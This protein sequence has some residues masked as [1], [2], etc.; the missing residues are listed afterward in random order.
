MEALIA[1]PSMGR[2]GTI[3]KG[4]MRNIP[5]EFHPN[6]KFFVPPDE[7]AKYKRAM[8]NC[9][10]EKVEVI[11]CRAE[12]IAATRSYIGGYAAVHGHTKFMMLD[13]DLNQFSVR[14]S[15]VDTK[16]RKAMKT[17]L[18]EMFETVEQYL[19]WYMHLS[20]STRFHN[21]QFVGER[22]IVVENFRMLRFL[23][24]RTDIFNTCQ[25]GRVAIAEDFDVTLQLLTR[26]YKNAVLHQWTH[27]QS[28]T[29][30]PGGCSIYR[31]LQ[32]HNENIEKLHD[33]WPRFVKIREK[34]NISSEAIKQ[35]LSSRLEAVID[36]KGA[37]AS[38]QE[39]L[40]HHP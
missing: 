7:V 36:W 39:G 17:D 1:I 19:D 5:D 2:S 8:W 23:C 4:T 27:D 28:V 38:S 37:F 12:G 10:F 26:G 31:T 6:V 29:N 24:Y 25:H 9:M 16:L 13:D 18:V 3:A 40:G 35:G 30:A 32:L 11:E 34:T 20:V 15:Q 14:I 33:L 22:P 21:E